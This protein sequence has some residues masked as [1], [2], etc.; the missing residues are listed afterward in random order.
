MM[1]SLPLSQARKAFAPLFSLAMTSMDWRRRAITPVSWPFLLLTVLSVRPIL[2]SRHGPLFV[3]L[4]RDMAAGAYSFAFPRIGD[5]GANPTHSLESS[6]QKIRVTRAGSGRR[7]WPR[8]LYI[9]S[10]IPAGDVKHALGEV[11]GVLESLRDGNDFAP[12]GVAGDT[13]AFQLDFIVA[14]K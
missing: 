7:R 8:G 4:L 6:F 9:G 2:F 10:P 1:R 5:A 3:V 13:A 14:R 11:P 12:K